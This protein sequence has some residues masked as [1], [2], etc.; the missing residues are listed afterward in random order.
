MKNIRALFIILFASVAAAAAPHLPL[1]DGNYYGVNYT[2]PFAHAYRALGQLE[3]DRKEAIDRDVYHMARLGLNAFRLHLWD[4]ELSDGEGRLLEDGNDHLDLLDY[5]IAQLEKRGIAVIL[6][7]QTNF[8]NGYPEKN[9][10]PNGSFSYKFDKCDVHDNPVAQRIQ[11]RYLHELVSHV[12][13]YTGKSYA[14]DPD[15]IAVEINNE[16]CHSGNARQITDYIDRM[17]RALRGAGWE[18]DIL[19]NVSH[20]LDRVEAYY[21][22]DD[23][24]GTTYQW[25]PTGL[26]HG[27]QRRGNFLPM[28]DSYDIPWDTIPG[29]MSRTRTIYEFDP[30]DVLDTYLYPAAARSFRKNGFTW[31]TQFAYDPID[32][33]RYNTEYQTH[34]LNLGYTPGKAVGMMIAAEV[35]RQVPSGADYGK[36]PADTVFGADRQFLVSARRNLAMLNDGERYY[37]T[38]T[39]D[40]LPVAPEKLRAISGVG[41]SP[42]V[43][44]D[45]LGAYFLDKISDDVW[46]LEVMPDVIITED[47]FAKPSLSRD[48][49]VITGRLVHFDI[50]LAALGLGDKFFYKAVAGDGDPDVEENDGSSLAVVPGVYLLSASKKSLDDVDVSRPFGLHLNMAISEYVAPYFDEYNDVLVHEPPG[51]V[52]AGR[53]FE[54]SAVWAG[55]N[56]PDSIVVY[57]TSASFWRENNRLFKM[58][59]TGKYG[60]SVEIPSDMVRNGSFGYRIVAWSDSVPATYPSAL[61]G[62]PLDWDFP[63]TDFYTVGSFEPGAPIE[64]LRPSPDMDG[65]ELTTIPEGWRGVGY[66]YEAPLAEAPALV[67][68]VGDEADSEFAVV[69]KYVAPVVNSVKPDDDY[70]TLRI[71][72]RGSVGNGIK[73]GIVNSDGFTYSAQIPENAS[74][75]VDIPLESFSLDSTVLSPA[76]FPAFL[77]RFFVP[78][79]TTATPLV[80]AAIETITFVVPRPAEIAIHGVQLVNKSSDANR[81]H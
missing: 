80:P 24:S 66:S 15:I 31:A 2:V 26:V 1:S 30:A 57:P 72:I 51:S 74:G 8:G 19:Y 55:D 54:I 77:S 21:A 14:S 10:D 43:S 27:A 42:I 61:P 50:S 40:V 36:Y 20:N 67:V 45:G 59:K 71:F 63:E 34:F 18:K 6:T 65:S 3:V 70:D 69:S 68:E 46:R 5:L 22:A 48:V 73:V 79:P 23:I 38:N 32:M 75:M 17:S 29:Y 47:P 53:P 81:L 58:K 16:P 7:A 25:Y 33:A 76:P 13:P 12:N 41:S 44:T 52:P 11:E 62:T 28:L 37:H 4:V 49:A 64:L 35:M 78:D 39:T 56:P 60:Y 9:T